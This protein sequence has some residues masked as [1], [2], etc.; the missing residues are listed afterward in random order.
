MYETE[1]DLLLSRSSDMYAFMAS[2]VEQLHQAGPVRGL[3]FH[4]AFQSGLLSFEH[5][6]SLLKL[7]NDGFVSSGF[8]LM[9]PQ[10]ECVIRGFWLMHADTD[11]W[12]RKIASLERVGL[13]ELKKYEP[14]MIADMFKALESSSAPTH[15]LG[16]LKAFREINNV[17]LNSFTHG[18]LIAL[19]GN[20]SG[21]QPKSIY[22]ALR[23]SN[24]VAA[25]NL[26][27]L[28]NLTGIEDA[29]SPVR[30]MHRDFT[31]CLPIIH[32]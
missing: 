15:I 26:Q 9:R 1:L 13:D 32:S 6:C 10:F 31:D 12:L 7:L 29:M 30:E 2:H 5:G 3:K 20:R 16:Q 8:A 22:D 28:S 14:P 19:I 18:G 21:H 17:A 24:A 27:M 4:A 11:T 25:I 23:N